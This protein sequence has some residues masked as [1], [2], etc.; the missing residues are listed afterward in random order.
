MIK[1]LGIE[2]QSDIIRRKLKNKQLK[3]A[4][5]S[6]RAVRPNKEGTGGGA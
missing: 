4:E 2:K 6:S 1:E 5:P 3:D